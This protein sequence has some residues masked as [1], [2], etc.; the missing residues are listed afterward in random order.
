MSKNYIFSFVFFTLFISG[1]TLVPTEDIS[2]GAEGDP[3]ANFS[4]YKTYA[5]LG[6]A[7]IVQDS[8]GQWEPPGFNADAEVKYLIGSELRDRGMS[9]NALSPDLSIGFVGGVN[10]DALGLN[11]D[12]ET[13]IKMLENVPRGGLMVVL[14]DSSTGFV[15]WVGVAR[16]EIQENVDIETV[17]AR[18]DYA[19]TQMM[20]QLPK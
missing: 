9:Y 7:T 16:A 3:K 20:I 19:V 2:V 13:S 8:F 4:S 1:C 14:V 17:K 5:W 11:L 18:L 15:V 6:S 12:S 10:M